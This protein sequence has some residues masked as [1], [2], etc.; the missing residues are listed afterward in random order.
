MNDPTTDKPL[1]TLEQL[2]Q[3]TDALLA[4]SRDNG[5]DTGDVQPPLSLAER[6]RQAVLNGEGFA[7]QADYGPVCEAA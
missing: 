4:A 1:A 3:A 2:E 7:F 6:A 5:S